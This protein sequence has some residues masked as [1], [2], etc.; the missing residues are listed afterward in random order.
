VVG[1]SDGRA[2]AEFALDGDL[3]AIVVEGTAHARILVARVSSAY[4]DPICRKSTSIL[5]RHADSVMLFLRK[6][7]GG[8]VI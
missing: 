7:K 4:I 6:K 8:G 5:E 3:E 1:R 2:A